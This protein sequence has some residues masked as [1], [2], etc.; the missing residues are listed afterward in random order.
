MK[1]WPKRQLGDL[2]AFVGG[3]TPRRDD[4]KYWGGDIPWAS[5]KDLGSQSLDTT[6]E[7]ITSDGLEHSASNL[8]P[9][10]TVIIASRV[11]LGKVAINRL[12]VAINQDLKALTPRD[13][14]LSPRYLLYFLL[15][16]A[17]QLENAGVGATV[18]GLTLA[19]YQKLDLLL[20]P[21]IEQTRIVR[22]LDEADALR[23]LRAKADTRMA[24]FIPALFHE[25]FGDP[26][27]N[28]K[29]WPVKRLGE[30]VTV[31]DVRLEPMNT[32]ERHFNY[33]GLEQIESGTGVLRPQAL[34]LGSQIRSIKNVFVAG[35]VL[36]GKLRPNL[37]KVHL[38]REE[39]ICSTDI[40]VLRSNH[41][42][43]RPAFVYA[44]M[45]LP[46]VISF[47]VHSAVGA[48][49]P[50][51]SAKSL[52]TLRMPLPPMSRQDAFAR[53]LDSRGSFATEADESRQR[54]EAL[55]QSMLHRAFE[56]EL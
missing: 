16:K 54:S 35:N 6:A 31:S 50:R 19:D 51:V 3:G 18:K 9:E 22:L 15:S 53:L 42:T 5:V 12:P 46:F 47:A 11:G 8:I 32:P 4:P 49:L 36:Y 30:F 17:S 39:G 44:I 23:K 24:D 13:S 27:T 25:M 40:L 34:T 43:A 48:N 7:F 37:N 26:I 45:N 28:P 33:V 29:G 55:F 1:N 2:V 56:G 52:M 41:D 38:A 21:S 14:S 20:P 10:G